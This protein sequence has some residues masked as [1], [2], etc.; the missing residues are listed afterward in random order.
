MHPAG[1]ALGAVVMVGGAGRGIYGLAGVYEELA[2]C[3]RVE[4]LSARHF[5]YRVPNH[6]NECV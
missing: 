2:N 5:E 6:L 1:A 3:L 4:G